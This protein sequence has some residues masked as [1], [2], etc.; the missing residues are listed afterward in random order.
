MKDMIV[1]NTGFVGSNLAAAHKFEGAFHST[2]IEQAYGARPE[3]LVYAGIRAEKYLANR[4]P[5]KD[6]EQICHAQKNIAA[7]SPQK[8]VLIS[9]ID[10]FKN[11]ADVDENTRIDTSGLHPYGYHRYRLE[12]WV[13]KH[14][15]DAVIIRLPGLYGKNLKKN[16]IYDYMHRIPSVLSRQKMN[17]LCQIKAGLLDY[18]EKL[19]GEFY[20]LRGLN[21]KEREHLEALFRETGFSALHFTDSRSRYQFYPLKRLWNDIQV[22]LENDIRL[23]HPVTEPVSAGELYEYLAGSPFVN[24]L[25]K[26]PADYRCRTIY[27]RLFGGKNGY[28]WGRESVMRQIKEFVENEAFDF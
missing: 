21:E 24:E 11:P 22:L 6:W 7:I 20:R 15:P 5:E 27:D 1:G 8:L 19:D 23:W 26:M 12:L 3:L 17:E 14:Y 28:L 2:D 4:E 9:S 10:I 13:R 18:Y 16:F 25:P